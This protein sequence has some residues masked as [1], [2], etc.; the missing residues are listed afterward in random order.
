[1]EVLQL[2]FDGGKS[3]SPFYREHGVS[4]PIVIQANNPAKRGGGR[5]R[6]GN[7]GGNRAGSDKDNKDGKDKDDGKNTFAS[8]GMASAYLIENINLFGQLGGFDAILR[9]IQRNST[10]SNVLA[11]VQ[12]VSVVKEHFHRN[13]GE[14]FAFSLAKEAVITRLESLSEPELKSI[15]K[16]DFEKCSTSLEEIL[17]R[18]MAASNAYQISEC[19]RLDFSFKLMQ[20]SVFDKR[21]MGVNMLNDMVERVTNKGK[22][23]KD[24]A[25]KWMEPKF[26]T[27]WLAEKKVRLELPE[28]AS[29]S[30]RVNN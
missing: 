18:W 4:A 26:L 3:R 16:A 6:G 7:Q 25:T 1:M 15:Q 2:I 21:V 13:F 8:N 5:G 30:I 29:F 28:F 22:K 11:L 23:A 17:V 20:S 10:V 24:N 9:R 27:T 19:F 14:T 12:L